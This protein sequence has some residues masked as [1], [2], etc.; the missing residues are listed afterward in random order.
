MDQPPVVQVI[1]E[2]AEQSIF[3]GVIFSKWYK[4]VT[5]KW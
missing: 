4:N 5:L 3:D 2:I 1:K